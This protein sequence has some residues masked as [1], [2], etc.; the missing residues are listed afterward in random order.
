MRRRYK[1]HQE[2]GGD[3]TWVTSAGRLRINPVGGGSGS[4]EPAKCRRQLRPRVPRDS[5]AFAQRRR[6]CGRRLAASSLADWSA[7][8]RAWARA[9]GEHGAGTFAESRCRTPRQRSLS[10]QTRST[11][12]AHLLL[13][14]HEDLA[15]EVA[16]SW[17]GGVAYFGR[18][19]AAP[20]PAALRHAPTHARHACGL[21]RAPRVPFSSIVTSV[22]AAIVG[23]LFSHRPSLQK[24]KRAYHARAPQL[25]PRA[26]CSVRANTRRPP[27]GEGNAPWLRRCGE[28]RRA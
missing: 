25:P 4:R 12:S 14:A 13:Y 20:R 26:Q 8:G 28:P 9:H 17:E 15:M 5:S 3:D 11:S 10:A 21:A 2:V 23:A 19:G 24:L 6:L 18:T 16:R 22:S 1:A 7:H 27:R